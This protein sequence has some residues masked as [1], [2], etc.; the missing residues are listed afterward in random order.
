MHASG[1]EQDGRNGYD[2]VVVGAGPA[3]SSAAAAAA[4]LG[5]R[6]LIV[7]RARFP[8]YKTCGGGL[9]GVSLAQLAEVDVPVRQEIVH[10]SFTHRGQQPA[11]RSARRRVLSLVDRSEFDAALLEHAVSLGVQVRSGVTVTAVTEDAYGA[12]LSSSDGPIRARYVVGADGSASRIARHVGVSLGQV[13]LGLEYELKAAEHHRQAWAGRVHMDWGPIPGSYG[14]VFPKGDTIT[15]GVI[16]R[17]GTADEARSYLKTFVEQQGLADAEVVHDSGHLTRCRTTDSPL[18]QGR[19]LVA[20]DAAGLL[21]PWTREGISYAL[22]SGRIAGECAAKAAGPNGMPPSMGDLSRVVR[23]YTMRITQE[24]GPEM[25]AGRAF[26]QAFER[27]PAAMHALLTRTPLGWR[28]FQRLGRGQTDVARVLRFAPARWL[29]RGL[30]GQP[31]AN[32][33]SNPA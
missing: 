24:L 15:V 26:L 7:D 11:R 23:D 12:L 32:P 31:V 28:E 19:V 22:R 33:A 8:R 21:E 29:L 16:A 6:T 2:V 18:G 20:G 14:W 27:H 25:A 17:R 9:I 4:R 5:A 30:S 1:I 13:D 10:A 3:G